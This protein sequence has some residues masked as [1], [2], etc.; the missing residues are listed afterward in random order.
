MRLISEIG[1]ERIGI[2]KLYQTTPGVVSVTC[3]HNS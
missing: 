2:E 1:D 3:N